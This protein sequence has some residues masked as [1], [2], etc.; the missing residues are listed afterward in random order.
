VATLS[1]RGAARPRGRARA[2]ALRQRRHAGPRIPAIRWIVKLHNGARDSVA[3]RLPSPRHDRRITVLP[4][5]T[6]KDSVARTIAA[7]DGGITIRRAPSDRIGSQPWEEVAMIAIH[8]HAKPYFELA[9]GVV[10]MKPLC[11][12]AAIAAI[13]VVT[14]LAV[15]AQTPGSEAPPAYR[16]SLGDLMTTTIQPRHIKLGF[17]GRE[18]NWVYA[19]YELHQLEEAL[20]RVSVTWPQWRQVRIVEMIETIIR[21][22][23][24]DLG[25]AIRTKNEAKYAEAYGQLTEACNSCHV[26]ARQVP[27]VIQDPK[28]SMFPDQDFR[29]KP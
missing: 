13:A 28:E 21:Q 19:T 4:V 6:K 15:G 16:P 5:G 10:M 3:S 8:R 27:I 22:P 26:G 14:P 11:R 1:H 29:P 24:Y 23:M 17:A 7:W 20:D 25:Q 18:Q 2:P 12:L 9:L